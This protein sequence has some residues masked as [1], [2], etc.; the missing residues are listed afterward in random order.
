MPHVH[1]KMAN[2]SFHSVY[3]KRETDGRRE[4]EGKKEGEE[5]KRE[6]KRKGGA[7]L[8]R[9]SNFMKWSAWNSVS[10]SRNPHVTGAELFL[11]TEKRSKPEET[12][13]FPR[14]SREHLLK[15]VSLEKRRIPGL[16]LLIQEDSAWKEEEGG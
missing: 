11:V 14:P 5:K 12:M 6:G 16:L 1:L 4:K 7:Q 9:D 15:V 13:L 2:V 8:S 3:T 10:A